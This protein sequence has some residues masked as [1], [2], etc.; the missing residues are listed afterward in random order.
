MTELSRT[1]GKQ[2]VDEAERERRIRR[3]FE[4]V[5]A[6]YDLMNDLMSMGIHRLWKR[7]L[8]RMAA[9]AA[10]QFIV[11]LAGGTGDVAALMAAPDRRVTVCDPSLP[12]MAVGRERGHAHVEW[13]EGTAEHMPLPSAS[14]DTITIAFGIRNV[15]RIED[16]L[17]EALRVLKPG[18]RFLCLEFSTPYA[19]VRP[20]YDLFS[21]TV[22]PR[23]GAWI[24]R[25]PEAYNYLVESIRRFPD[26]RAFQALIE[27]AGFRDAS[28]RNL[29]FGIACIH[30]ASRPAPVAQG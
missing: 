24:A 7:S 4:V 10:G 18:G 3:V 17:A 28:Y 29:S 11:D 1:F 16:A 23:L 30:V 22:I 20:F 8:V 13:L 15:T 27:Q 2:A 6:R 14:V 26:Q 25:A 21:L 19:L 12:M 9:P 5:A